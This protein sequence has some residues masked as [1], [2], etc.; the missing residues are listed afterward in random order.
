MSRK[1][2]QRLRP[3]ATVTL[4]WT[5]RAV[6]LVGIGLG[7]LATPLV[8]TTRIIPPLAPHDPVMVIV[9]DHGDTPSLVLP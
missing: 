5:A 2:A 1:A 9:V 8:L 4:R 3:L 7:L 6:L